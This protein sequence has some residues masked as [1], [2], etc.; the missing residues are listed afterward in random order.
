MNTPEG[1]A[2]NLT[3]CAFE[4]MAWNKDVIGNIP[5]KIQEKR[6]ALNNLTA[7]DHDGSRGAEIDEL[8]KEINELLDSDEIL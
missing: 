2:S 6:K 1:I 5:R 3:H 4:L 7:Q 8:R